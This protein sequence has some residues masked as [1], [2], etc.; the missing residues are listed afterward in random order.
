MKILEKHLFDYVF[1]PEVLTKEESSHISSNIE[2]YI[3]EIKLLRIIKKQLKEKISQDIIDDIF[4]RINI[5]NNKTV[6]LL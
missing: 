4:Q 1:C 5:R 2:L 6:V 3:H